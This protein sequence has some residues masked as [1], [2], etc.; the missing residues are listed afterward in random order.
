MADEEL[1]IKRVPPQ[2]QEAERS[3]VGAM[4]M[5]REAIEIATEFISGED[6]YNRQLGT[7]FDAMV[8]LNKEGKPVDQ[9]TLQEKLRDKNI[10]PEYSSTE[11]I[12]GLIQAVPTSANVK[13]YAKIVNNTSSAIDIDDISFDFTADGSSSTEEFHN[14]QTI[15]ANGNALYN[16]GNSICL[17]SCNNNYPSATISNGRITIW[18]GSSTSGKS[19]TLDKSTIVNGDTITF[20]YNG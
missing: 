10:P 9:V 20:T 5:D 8:E 12:V 6:F 4:L 11:Y 1:M 18:E 19:V 7:F 2:S 14:R 16:H 13:Y 15:P 17:D 3:V